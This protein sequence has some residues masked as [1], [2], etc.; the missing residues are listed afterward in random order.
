MT[1][2]TEAAATI[3]HILLH[4]E[5]KILFILKLCNKYF[6]FLPNYLSKSILHVFL[7]K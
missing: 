4:F 6:N 5:K 7:T 1:L 3:R 2:I